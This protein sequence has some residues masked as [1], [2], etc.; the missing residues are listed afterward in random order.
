MAWKPPPYLASP[1]FFIFRW[2][3]W[4]IATFPAMLLYQSFRWLK[5]GHWTPMPLGDYVTINPSDISWRGL[6]RIV[7]L[8]L[9]LH[10]GAYLSLLALTATWLFVE[11]IEPPDWPDQA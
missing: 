2:L 9:D 6:A 11:A 10:I 7:E 8:A 5:E 3:P 4:L 1:T